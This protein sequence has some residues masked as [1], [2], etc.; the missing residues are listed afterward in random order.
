MTVFSLFPL[1]GNLSPVLLIR[2]LGEAAA[3][4]H[5]AQAHEG[6]VPEKWHL[7]MA[8]TIL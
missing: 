4:K 1:T 6:R 8:Y 3:I 2:L 7:Q 5:A